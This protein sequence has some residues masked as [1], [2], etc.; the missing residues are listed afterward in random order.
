MHI[1][2]ERY[3]V[4]CIIVAGILAAVASLVLA[5]LHII[6]PKTV[7]ELS[8]TLVS[9]GITL[10]GFFLTALSI[11]AGFSGTEFMQQILGMKEAYHEMVNTFFVTIIANLLLAVI[12]LVCAITPLNPLYSGWKTP[13]SLL[14]LTS[15]AFFIFCLILTSTSL[16][17]FYKILKHL[18]K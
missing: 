8:G 7:R 14:P 12:A 4:R 18:A 11:L 2:P 17:G 9:I 1:W 5:R 6:E 3:S 13:A 15:C 16:H 10:G